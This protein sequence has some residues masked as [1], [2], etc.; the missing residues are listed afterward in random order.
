MLRL[1]FQFRRTST[2]TTF[3]G[4]EG[5]PDQ[6]S[7]STSVNVRS[8]RFQEVYERCCQHKKTGQCTC[9][10]SIGD[11]MVWSSAFRTF[12]DSTGGGPFS[13][14]RPRVLALVWRRSSKAP[15]SVPTVLPLACRSSTLR[16]L[17]SHPKP[18]SA[19]DCA[20]WYDS[21]S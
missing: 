15:W 19:A 18:Q 1:A 13:P 10:I 12:P 8:N 5:R 17:L 3:A 20:P 14:T 21:S 16:A 2:C 11:G 7:E 4:G 6:R 9:V